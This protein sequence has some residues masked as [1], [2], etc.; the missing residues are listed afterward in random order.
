MIRCRPSVSGG[1]VDYQDT[2]IRYLHDIE[3]VA[4]QVQAR[5][6]GDPTVALREEKPA[7]GLADGDEARVCGK[8]DQKV[9][10]AVAELRKMQDEGL[11]RDVG[12]TGAGP[13]HA[14]R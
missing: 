11:I 9:L 13:L 1:G 5:P 12:I 2:R 10:E 4:T 14:P 7:W 6:T 3:Y 8:G